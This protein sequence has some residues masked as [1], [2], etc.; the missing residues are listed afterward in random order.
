MKRFLLLL[1]LGTLGLG[2]CDDTQESVEPGSSSCITEKV[3]QFAKG[4][5]CKTSTPTIGASVKEYRF[6]E[7]LVY[8]FDMGNCLADASADVL[9]ANCQRIGMLGGLAGIN[10]VNGESFEKAELQRTLWQQ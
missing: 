2:S 1:T 6:Q 8:V 7:R 10:Q 4:S 3:Q 9:D 5:S